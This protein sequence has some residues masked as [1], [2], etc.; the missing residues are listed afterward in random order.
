MK[1]RCSVKWWQRWNS[2]IDRGKEWREELKNNQKETKIRKNEIIEK[3]TRIIKI[4]TNKVLNKNFRELPLTHR[5]L[6]RGA[7]LGKA[8]K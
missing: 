8:L 3:S 5:V 2:G 4:E 7:P 1:W 6:E